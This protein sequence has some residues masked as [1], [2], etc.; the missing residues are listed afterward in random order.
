MRS[1]LILLILASGLAAQSRLL[2]TGDFARIEDS[3]SRFRWAADQKASISSAAEA[4]PQSHLSRYGLREL[5]LPPEGG[6]W[7]HW[8]VCPTTGV[9]LRFEAPNGNVCPSDNRRLTGWPYD[10][11]IY[12]ER[13]D[14]L[15]NAARD[16]ALAFRLTGKRAYA[17]QAAWILNAYADRYVSMALHDKDNRNTRSG[18]RVHAQTLDE[19]IWLIPMA[20]AYDLLAGSDVLTQEQRDRIERD[21]LRAATATI[22]RNDMGISNW[23]S[24]HNAGMAAVA[25]CLNDRALIE[26]VIEGPSGFRFQLKNSVTG[27]GFWYEGSFTYHY[28]ALDALMQTAEMAVR[29]GVDLFADESFARMFSAPARFALPDG[30]LAPFNDATT[31]NLRNYNRWYESAYARWGDPLFAMIAGSRSRGREALLW[32]VPELPLAGERVPQKST[33]FP[34]S[35]YAVLRSATD[36]TVILKYGPHGGGHGHF[37]KLNFVSYAREGILAVDPGTQSYAAPTHATW[38]QQT[39]AHNTIVVDERTQAAATGELL[40]SQLTPDYS[41]VRANA[42]PVYANA[43]LTRSLL[44]TGDYALD[45]FDATST[46]GKERQFDW[47]YHNAGEVLTDLPLN[48]GATLPRT[49][50]YQHLT[51]NRSA[52]TSGDW[53]LRFDGSRLPSIAYG[54][55]FASTSN[56]KGSFA[57]S[58]EQTYRGSSSGKLGYQFNGAGYLLYTTAAVPIQQPDVAPKGI[59]LMLYGDGSRHRVALRLNDASDERFVSPLITI[60]WNG[61]KEIQV[62][63]PLRWTHYL[64]NNDGV[65]DLPVRNVSFELQQ[66]AGSPGEGAI[67]ADDIDLIYEIEEP[68]RVA[69]FDAPIRGVRLWMLGSAEGATT[70][71]TGNGLGEDLTRPVS[72]VMARRRTATQTQ[73]VTLL[74]PY[75]LEPAV[76]RFERL[77]DGAVLIAGP[78]WRD[79]IRFSAVGVEYQRE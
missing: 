75:G 36:H 61:W 63:A 48:S 4:W 37:D 29:S 53:Q 45:I 13:H 47:M 72:Y 67:Y 76:L 64:G 18:A 33:I 19:A 15:A 25:F 32:G 49:A 30:T 71:V 52:S 24:W 26:K 5:A 8:Y 41:Y 9:R 1:L 46:D 31:V 40:A 62:T 78:N 16:L 3:T 60:D 38:Y 66:T 34:D 68:V 11:V 77:S 22:D 42:G 39:V 70:V 23:Q 28:Y 69:E 51:G 57:L 74:E 27:D 54:T 50:G 56:V 17:E 73:F 21:L 14:A 7:W 6:Q 59:R 58:R 44:V 79:T 12:G 43:R 35:G 65:I 20:W 2:T 55:V 10:Q